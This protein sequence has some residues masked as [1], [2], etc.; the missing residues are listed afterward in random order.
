MAPCFHAE[1]ALSRDG[2]PYSGSIWQFKLIID[3]DLEADFNI[4]DN[5]F[6]YFGLG[7]GGIIMLMFCG[8]I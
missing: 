7:P 5:C 1:V 2:C 6:N 8:L 4:F 3:E